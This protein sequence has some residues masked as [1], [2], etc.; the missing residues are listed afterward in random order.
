MQFK[1][2][3]PAGS[4]SNKAALEKL[5]L[6]SLL[7]GT[8]LAAVLSAVFVWVSPGLFVNIFTYDASVREIFPI[9]TILVIVLTILLLAPFHEGAHALLADKKQLVMGFAPKALMCYVAPYGE[10]NKARAVLMALL[11]FL[12][13][14]GI[15]FLAAIFAVNSSVVAWALVVSISHALGCGGD[16]WG[17]L[18]I[19]KV[20]GCRVRYGDFPTGAGWVAVPPST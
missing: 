15:P 18:Q 6:Y 4:A 20:Q 11:P 2:G 7:L 17:C 13:F 8:A 16:I 5:Q 1:I 3:L 19:L 12:M 9:P 14:T 10:Y